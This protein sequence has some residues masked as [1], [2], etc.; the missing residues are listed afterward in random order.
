MRG[1]AANVGQNH[2]AVRVIECRAA[3]EI[4]HSRVALSLDRR[5]GVCRQWFQ[6]CFPSHGVLGRAEHL[7]KV[8]GIHSD[9][10]P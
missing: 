6:C 9:K 2:R 3:I 4:G 7:G 10:G 8:R 1:Q 5:L